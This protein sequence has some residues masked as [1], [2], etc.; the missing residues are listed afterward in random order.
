MSMKPS[1]NPESHLPVGGR[2]LP[3]VVAAAVLLASLLPAPLVFAQSARAR[4]APRNAE[5]VTL[6]FVNADIDGVARAMS[7]ILK[8]QFVVDPRVKG[9]MTLYSDVPLTPRDAYV[10]FLAS[11][12]GLGFT[13]VEQLVDKYTLRKET[14]RQG[15]SRA[16]AP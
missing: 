6:N 8:Q 5:T 16:N 1:A 4:P 11:L 3:T 13:V 9:T 12:R 2:L 7:A 14:W 10:N 15:A